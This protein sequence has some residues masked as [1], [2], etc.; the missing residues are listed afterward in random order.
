MWWFQITIELIRI[1]DRKIIRGSGYLLRTIKIKRI[2]I[3]IFN[4]KIDLR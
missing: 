3:L 1:Y 4:W 2:I